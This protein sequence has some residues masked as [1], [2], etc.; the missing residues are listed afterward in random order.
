MKKTTILLTTVLFATTACTQRVYQPMLDG[1]VT[2][3]YQRDLTE[4]RRL[5]A[6][7]AQTNDG[8]TGGAIVG[9]LVGAAESDDG[10][11]VEGLIAGAV[12][13]GLIGSAEDKSEIKSERD[14]IVF[15]CLRGRGHKVVG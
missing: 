15:N 12:I 2:A 11:E 5:A 8:R 14:K 9:G 13:G 4:C 1:P 6:T 10:D 7:K 3:S